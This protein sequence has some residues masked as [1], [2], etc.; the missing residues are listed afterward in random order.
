ILVLTAATAT[1]IALVTYY[2][3]ERERQGPHTGAL[4]GAALTAVLVTGSALRTAVSAV[5]TAVTPEIW[6]AD[7]TGYID[8][9][10]PTDWQCPVAAALLAMLGYLA[11]SPAWRID[12]AVFGGAVVMFS[13]PGTG[14]VAWWAVP[15]LAAAASTVGTATALYAR[16]GRSASLRSAAAAV[17]GVSALAPSLARA[18][19]PAPIS[20]V[21]TAVAVTPARLATR[22][23]QRFGPY[24]DRIADAAGGAAAFTL[25]I[26]VGT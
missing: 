23:P 8:R 17:L 5:R 3:P 13:L 6:H 26:A 16:R 7:L 9:L 10:Y 4:I 1:A 25:P 20:P 11:T 24:A 18:E 2:L 19:P 12:A 22:Q 14:A 21:L 15:V